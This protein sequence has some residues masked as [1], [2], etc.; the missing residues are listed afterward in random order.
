MK[1]TIHSFADKWENNPHLVLEQTSNKSGK[2]FKWI[3]SRNGFSNI[4]QLRKYLK[5]KKRILDAGCG[6]GRVTK[7]LRKYSNKKAEIT[8][9]D[10]VD[11]AL[12]A[13]RNNLKD[14][15][16][17]SFKKKNL[18]NSLRDLGKFDFIYCQEV[19]HH[20]AKPYIAFKNLTNILENGGEIA[21]YV[22]RKKAPV[23]EFMDDYIREKIMNL[24]F[25]DAIKVCEKI[26]L[27]GK[28]LYEKK[29]KINIPEIDIL[30]IPESSYTL[31]RFVY[32]FFMKCFW[33]PDLTFYENTIINY[34]YYHPQICFRYDISQIREWFSKT[35]L[36]VTHEYQDHYGIT[37][38]G[39]K[40]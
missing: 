20:T 27:L 2:I 32:H 35:K 26:T 34:D 13:A 11:S 15:E 40:L 1:Q 16:N 7:L 36:K 3:L 23:R 5:I 8:G 30:K 14:F 18:L 28:I 39:K 33:N 17:V 31:Q 12:K 29:T 9:I 24:S 38:R 6:N 25:D 37:I 21:I 10:I 22:Y 4:P 19:L